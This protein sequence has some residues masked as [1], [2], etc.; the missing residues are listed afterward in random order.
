MSVDLDAFQVEHTATTYSSVVDLKKKK[1]IQQFPRKIQEKKG[2]S[3]IQ[4]QRNS[5]ATGS[6]NSET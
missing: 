6:S 1:I 5:T 3:A 2:V 4:P